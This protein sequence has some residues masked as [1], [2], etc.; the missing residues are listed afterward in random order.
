MTMIMIKW[1]FCKWLWIMSHPRGLDTGD[2]HAPSMRDY[3]ERY[4]EGV[5]RHQRVWGEGWGRGK[6]HLCKN[7][8]QLWSFIS[9]D[10]HSGIKPGIKLPFLPLI[11]M[12]NIWFC[13]KVNRAHLG[14]GRHCAGVCGEVWGCQ[15]RYQTHITHPQQREFF[16]ALSNW[17]H[18]IHSLPQKILP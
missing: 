6:S 5:E 7:A 12:A 4:L 2:K 14:V 10:G 15:Q 11:L 9:Y 3:R 17:P 13:F 1:G 18:K 16:K 8:V